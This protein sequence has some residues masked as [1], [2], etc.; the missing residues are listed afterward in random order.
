MNILQGVGF[1]NSSRE[2]CLCD[3]P[4][5]GR[6]Q[7]LNDEVLKAANEQDSSLTCGELAR[8]FNVSDE[9]VRLHLHH[10]GKAYKLNK[11]VPHTLSEVHKRQQVAACVSLLSRHRTAS[12]FN[13]VLTSDE[14]WVLY[15]TPK[16]FRHWLSPQYAV[17][18]TARPPM[19]PHKI[20]LYVWW[21]GH[22]VVHYELLPMGQMVTGDLY[23]QQ[24]E[25][26]Q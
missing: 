7:V 23:S 4:R 16:H 17:P 21:T 1:K 13:R 2:I 5:S 25:C 9:T 11:W 19:H 3:E 6:P 22:Q 12:L 18:H 15:E 26:V 24:L 20:M 8:Q 10:L 14:K